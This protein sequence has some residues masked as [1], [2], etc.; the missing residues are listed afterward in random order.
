MLALEVDG[1][2]WPRSAMADAVVVCSDGAVRRND[3][4]TPVSG[5][6]LLAAPPGS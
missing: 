5:A 4:A 2:G 6:C 3:A 1:A